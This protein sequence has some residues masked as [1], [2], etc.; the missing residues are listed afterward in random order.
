MIT[1]VELYIKS[2]IIQIKQLAMIEADSRPNIFTN[3]R[4]LRGNILKD[5]PKSTQELYYPLSVAYIWPT[6]YCPIGCEHCMY[7]SP[8]PKTK[9][10]GAVLNDRALGNFIQLSKDSHLESLV[11]SGGGEPMLELP[12]I[13]RLLREAQFKYFEI[14]TG[15]HWLLSDKA[16]IKNLEKLQQTITDRKNRGDTIDFSIRLSVDQFHQKMVKPE[17]VKRLIDILREDA[18]LPQNERKYPDIR[19][20]LRALLIEDPTIDE[21]A[22]MLGAELS[23]MEGY[24]RKLRFKDHLSYG[25]NELLIF[26]KDMRFVG[27]G[28]DRV[29][30]KS[31]E[32]DQYFESYSSSNGDIR[33]GMTYLKPGSKGEVLDGINIFVRHDGSIMPYGGAPDV[34]SNID[35]ESYREFLSKLWSDIISRTLLFKGV[36]HVKRVAEEIDPNVSERARHKNWIASIVDESLSTIEVRLYISI[37]LL[38]EEVKNGSINIDQ[39]PPYVQELMS[40]SP[41]QLR[42]DYEKHMQSK[43]RIE[44]SYAHEGIKV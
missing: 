34:V 37:R 28:R 40:I 9:D 6:L 25:I 32:L 41:E 15:G 5:Y 11:V 31:V 42:K 20:F 30:T 33:L 23:Q 36:N 8:K 22:N 1:E 21:I 7:S 17:R 10:N 19:L 12:S 14:T 26:Y 13:L 4:E 27:R 43:G 18:G 39:L 38:Q 24:T 35:S 2:V 44:K 16:I 29:D 3:A